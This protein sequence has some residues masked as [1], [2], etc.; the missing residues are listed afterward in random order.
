MELALASYLFC[1]HDKEV[2][3]AVL[4]KLSEIGLIG[5]SFKGF[6]RRILAYKLLLVSVLEEPN[7][8]TKLINEDLLAENEIYDQKFFASD[9]GSEMLRMLLSLTEIENYSAV[10]Y[11]NEGFWKVLRAFASAERH[12][13]TV[14]EYLSSFLMS[15]YLV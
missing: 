2:G 15:L 6:K 9:Q 14:F 7:A 4:A 13:G 8:I 12:T 11:Q 1:K 3:K 10:L 5:G